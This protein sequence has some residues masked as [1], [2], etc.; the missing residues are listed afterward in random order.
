MAN[1]N[2]TVYSF[3]KLKYYQGNEI[4]ALTLTVVIV[5][6]FVLVFNV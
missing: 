2:S 6:E 4:K 5:L 1:S 3:Y